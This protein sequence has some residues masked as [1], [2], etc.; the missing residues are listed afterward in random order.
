MSAEYPVET[1]AR[2]R[3]GEWEGRAGRGRGCWVLLGHPWRVIVQDDFRDDAGDHDV[4]VLAVE[5]PAPVAEPKAFG[6]RVEFGP[7]GERDEAVLVFLEEE[8][9][10]W[11][12]TGG[13]HQ[14]WSDLINPV[15]LHDPEADR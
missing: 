9:W 14:Q 6:A 5:L 7:K 11:I 3:V 4:T 12:S 10:R 13:I 8:D 2:V 15:V 1:I